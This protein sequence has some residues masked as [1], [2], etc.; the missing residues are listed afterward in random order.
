MV[1]VRRIA[2]FAEVIVDV[3]ILALE[4]RL[5]RARVSAELI[6][7]RFGVGD[8]T[9]AHSI[10]EK[11]LVDVFVAR[12]SSNAGFAIAFERSVHVCAFAVGAHSVLLA[13]VVVNALRSVRTRVEALRTLAVEPTLPTSNT[14][15]MYLTGSCY[16]H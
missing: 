2:V 5:A 9:R 4:T 14:N 15:L 1:G 3:A 13:L 11:T 10:V 12:Q 6:P 7:A 16:A 8:V